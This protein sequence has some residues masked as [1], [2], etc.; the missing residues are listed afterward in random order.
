M[1]EQLTSIVEGSGNSHDK[2]DVSDASQQMSRYLHD[3]VQILEG[4]TNYLRHTDTAQIKS[5]LQERVRQ[6]PLGTVAVG[7]GIGFLLG[8]LFR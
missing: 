5:D 4:F 1:P 8:K 7:I 2:R 3:F 6:N